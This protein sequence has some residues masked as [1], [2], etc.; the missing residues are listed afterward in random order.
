[1]RD[2]EDQA[3]VDH[4][5]RADVRDVRQGV[6][7]AQRGEVFLPNGLFDLQVRAMSVGF[8]HIRFPVVA[9]GAISEKTS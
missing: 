7:T 4:G 5:K 1:M 3:P 2:R 8:R 9:L 6:E